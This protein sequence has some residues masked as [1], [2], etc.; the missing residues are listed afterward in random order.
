MFSHRLGL[1]TDPHLIIQEVTKNDEG[2]EQVKVLN[3]P[4]T[5]V[6]PD[7]AQFDTR[8]SDVSYKFVAAVDAT[9]R[10]TIREGYSALR[11]DPRLVYRL[12]IR[13]E[14]PDFR[15]VAVPCDP[16][17]ALVLRKGDRTTIDVLA[18]RRDGLNEPITL[19][20]T[21]LPAG[22]TSAP[23][24]LGPSMRVATLVL[25]AADNA[26]VGMA[27]LTIVG[28]A[29]IAG[30]DITRTARS[31]TTNMSM[32]MLV[33][34]QRA[35]SSLP[36][37]ISHKIALSVIDGTS[38]FAVELKND[39]VWETTRAGILKIP[40]TAKRHK[41]YKGQ[42][43]CAIVNL[44]ANITRSTFNIAANNAA[45]EFQLTLRNNTPAGTYTLH[46]GAYVAA[47]SYSRNP[48]A[49]EAAKQRKVLIDKIATDAATASKTATAAKQQADKSATDTANAV[50]AAELKMTQAK[51]AE[52]DAVAA[53]QKA[54]EASTKAKAVL[55]AKPE[56]AA[57][58]TA[59]TAAE[60]AAT[61]AA[62]KAKVSITAADRKSVV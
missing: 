34:N 28:K 6:P 18:E 58:N 11:S 22:V 31:A 26:V 23:V 56:E 62:A 20:V 50:K 33:P 17:G 46:A 2:E 53:E 40:Y 35:P 25:S 8:T 27:N 21:G 7:R 51:K 29:K 5:T 44:P 19:T 41:D 10:L 9:Y 36:A 16:W 55:A 52:T 3:I 4:D 24:T 43:Q 30:R 14:Q 37:R 45:G 49:A 42:V 57:L 38:P 59:V 32:R 13:K 39:K 1:P 61:D 54:A 15:L 12:A 47:Y 60:K 48:E